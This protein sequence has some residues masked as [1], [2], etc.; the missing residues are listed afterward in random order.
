MDYYLKEIEDT[1]MLFDLEQIINFQLHHDVQII[2]GED[3]QYVCYIDGKAY[4]PSLT[5]MLS[6]VHG[7]RMFNESK[8]DK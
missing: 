2:R 4:T 6:L 8:K 7:I 5:P 1:R 3:Y